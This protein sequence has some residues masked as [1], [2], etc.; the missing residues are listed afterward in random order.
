MAKFGELIDDRVQ[1]GT[2]SNWE[3]GKNLPNNERLKII[4]SLGDIS[5]DELLYGR[6]VPFEV[7]SGVFI[8]FEETVI[9]DEIIEF[10][11][12]T[13]FTF[14]CRIVLL[15]T[16]WLKYRNYVDLEFYAYVGIN[17]FIPNSDDE[18][19]Y[20]RVD[21]LDNL[22]EPPYENIFG[23]ETHL[24]V[25]EY[26]VGIALQTDEL[27]DKNLTLNDLEPSS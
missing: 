5:I 20:Y 14:K 3:T 24:K 13:K 27:K 17:V 9:S 22:Y 21:G 23:C 26:L 25:N 11:D 2:V 8:E 1:S 15:T 4:A 19:S 7:S 12:S 10:E 18:F 16:D 6:N